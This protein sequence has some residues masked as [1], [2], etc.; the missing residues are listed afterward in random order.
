MDD[1]FQENDAITAAAY[2]SIAGK[3]AFGPNAGKYVTRIGSGF[4]YFEEV[5]LAK[6]KRCFSANGFSLHC[7]TSTNTHARDR[8]EKLIE[9][10]ARGPL[11][12]ERLE[13]TDDGKV[14]LQLKTAWR[15][16]TSHLLLSPH[17]KI[18]MTPQIQNK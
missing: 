18:W 11:S 8:L 16:G 2:A 12:N 17:E 4:G 7:N 6:G 13:I 1:L 14:K 15:D 5:P 10:I 3:I 9:Y